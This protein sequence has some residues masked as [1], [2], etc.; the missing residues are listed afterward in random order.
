M[1]SAKDINLQKPKFYTGQENITDWVMS[2][3]LDGI[4]GYWDGTRLL[5]RKGLPLNPPPWFIEKFP[6]FELDG[7]LWSG[8]GEY[9]FIQSVVLDKIPGEGWKKITY[10]IFEVPHSKGPF[11]ERLKRA[12]QWF[13]AHPCPHA[14]IIRQ[15]AVGSPS[16]LDRFLADIES[17]GGEGVIIKDPD[18]PYHTGRSPHVL[19]VKNFKDMEGRVTAINKGKGKYKDVMGSLVITLENGTVFKLGTGFTDE[20]RRH[21]PPV[22]SIVSFKYHGVTKNG[23]PKFASYLRIRTD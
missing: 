2:E 16:A 15:F 14:R 21:P 7:E 4:R 5:T 8:R 22:G 23:I 9:E 3:K 6:T 17:K 10:N 11:F 19:K 18:R 20:V 12:E 13:E 1:V